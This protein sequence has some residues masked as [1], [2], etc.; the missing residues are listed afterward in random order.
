MAPYY[1][2]EGS[3]EYLK[4]LIIYSFLSERQQIINK[5]KMLY[6]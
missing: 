1:I 6:I 5:N 2:I 4:S 3:D